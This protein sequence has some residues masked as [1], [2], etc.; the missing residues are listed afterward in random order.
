MSALMLIFSRTVPVVTSS[1][2]R[3]SG[4]GMP[5]YILTSSS[6]T[7]WFELLPWFTKSLFLEVYFLLNVEVF[8]N[9]FQV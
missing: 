4:Q 9:M 3:Y 6:S 5:P 7:K 1:P 8:A 2:S